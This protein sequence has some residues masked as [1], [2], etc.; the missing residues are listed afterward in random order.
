LE[1]PSE[2]AMHFFHNVI[3]KGSDGTTVAK[4]I[5]RLYG[6]KINNTSMKDYVVSI[7]TAKK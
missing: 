2:I 3:S 4:N 6:L 1:L 5:A 7:L